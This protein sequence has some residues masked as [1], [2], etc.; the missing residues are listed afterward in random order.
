MAGF[1]QFP[2]EG[3]EPCRLPLRMMEQKQRRHRDMI[4]MR[5]AA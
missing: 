1:P 2:S 5:R 4:L 3:E